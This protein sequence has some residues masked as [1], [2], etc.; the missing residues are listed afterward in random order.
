MAASLARLCRYRTELNCHSLSR[1]SISIFRNCSTNTKKGVVLGAYENEDGEG[2]ILSKSAE[3]FNKKINGKLGELLNISGPAL[4]KGK[5]RVFYGL[6]EEFSSVA[7]VGVGKEGVGFNEHEGLDESLENVR[8]A[9]S[10]GIRLL[11]KA[12]A[13][14]VE[15]EPF[16]CAQAS[17][18]GSALGLY[19]YDELKD[20]KNKQPE[21]NIELHNGSSEQKEA[22]KKGVILADCQNFARKLMEMP[23]N[24]LYPTSFAK[25]TEEKLPWI[26]E[27]EI[28]VHHQAWIEKMKMG[29]FFS[30]TKG[31]SQP[32]VFMELVYKGGERSSKPLVL[33]GKGVTFDSG[34]ISIKPSAKMDVMRG[35]MG[36][37]ANVV[38]AISAIA[39]LK[40]PIN[41]TGLV[42]LCENMVNGMATRPG[43]VV[44]AMNGKTIQID[45]TDAEGRLLLADALCFACQH[46]NP[47]AI[48]DVATLT[49]AIDIALGSGVTGLFTNSTKLWDI[50]HQAGGMT[51]DRV[52]RMPLLQHYTKQ[53]SDSQLADLNNIGTSSR[54]AGACT[55]AA[56]LQEFVT[57]PHWAHLDIAGVMHT[58]TQDGVPYISKGM[59]GRPMRTLVEFAKQF[60][61]VTLD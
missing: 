31:S 25:I 57:V 60:V 23:A 14:L 13:N 47:A 24:L 11:R 35:D 34:G 15:V 46:H 54:S 28:I 43:D 37:A 1:F 7:V 3:I 61:T 4:K 27:L 42:P 26:D 44:T 18:E 9:A 17:A 53:I 10:A 49:G 2:F 55:A 39:S 20:V 22:W 58:N 19:E 52:W 21:V 16:S 8:I 36:G 50:F 33:V 32:P 45:N 6:D 56:F 29:A 48:V 30:V 59:S 41:V 40:L 38:A 5:A 51:G 12:G